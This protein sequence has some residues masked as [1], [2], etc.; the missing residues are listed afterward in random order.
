MT[1]RYRCR[2]R[3]CEWE[4]TTTDGIARD[5]KTN[6]PRCPLCGDDVGRVLTAEE[7]L[8]LWRGGTRDLDTVVW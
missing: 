6:V 1:R 5:P 3:L 8:D 4:A 7:F 2:N